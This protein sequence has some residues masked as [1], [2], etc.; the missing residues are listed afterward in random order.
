MSCQACDIAQERGQLVSYVRVGRANVLI[1]GCGDHLREL[2]R[3]YQL[4]L[5]ADALRLEA[6]GVPQKTEN[7]V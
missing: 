5:R 4:G 7:E 2:I 6:E 3:L 1:A